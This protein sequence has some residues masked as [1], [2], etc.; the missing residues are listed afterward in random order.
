MLYDLGGDDHVEVT[1]STAKELISGPDLEPQV[2]E[3]P[4]REVNDRRNRVNAKALSIHIRHVRQPPAAAAEIED[5]QRLRRS[6]AMSECHLAEQQE[7]GARAP[8]LLG[9]WV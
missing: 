2:R 7:D 4:P 3:S 8:S 5:P 1:L 9:V 6:A